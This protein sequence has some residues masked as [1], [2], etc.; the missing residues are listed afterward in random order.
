MFG[1]DVIE[2]SLNCK[3]DYYSSDEGDE[4]NN[5]VGYNSMGV[6]PPST[7]PSTQRAGKRKQHKPWAAGWVDNPAQ[8]EV[9]W[10]STS[11]EKLQIA[12]MRD[13]PRTHLELDGVVI[14][15]FDAAFWAILKLFGWQ[16]G[17][18]VIYMCT[19]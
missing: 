18:R 3:A 7:P 5:K 8:P 15:D 16:Q 2:L 19:G 14:D 12:F 13:A 9:M 11:H 17:S 10:S 6:P 1:L 4:F